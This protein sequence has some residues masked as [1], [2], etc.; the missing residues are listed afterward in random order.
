MVLDEGHIQRWKGGDDGN[1]VGEYGRRDRGVP[2]QTPMA[3]PYGD[4]PV[5]PGVSRALT[6]PSNQSCD[7][8]RPT[9]VV[10]PIGSRGRD[11]L[12]LSVSALHRHLFAPHNQR[13]SSQPCPSSLSC[14]DSSNGQRASPHLQ[15]CAIFKSRNLHPYLLFTLSTEAVRGVTEFSS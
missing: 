13:H 10:V 3:G 8:V 2:R 15:P 1:G 5:R 7:R 14:A 9:S 6:S 12:L 4:L 11:S